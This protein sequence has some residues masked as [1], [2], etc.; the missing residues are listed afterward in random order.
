MKI[1]L[2][3]MDVLS[4]TIYDGY[5]LGANNR[6]SGSIPCTIC[7]NRKTN[8]DVR[9]HFHGSEFG[10]CMMKTYRN[11]VEGNDANDNNDLPPGGE[12]DNRAAS[13]LDGHS[14]ESEIFKNLIAA[15]LDAIGFSN[16]D[17]FE[18]QVQVFIKR[19]N[20][21]KHEF[22]MPHKRIL[23][24]KEDAVAE[25]FIKSFKMI[26]HLDG[27][28]EV[29]KHGELV[30]IECKS[31]GEYT[32]KKIKAS[33][34]ISD[35]WYG[36]IQAYMLWNHSIT[37]FYLIVKNRQSSK[38]LKPILI[39]RDDK[40]INRRLNILYRIFKAIIKE[41]PVKFKIEKEHKTA[42][43]SECRFCDYKDDCFKL[44]LKKKENTEETDE[45][46]E[47]PYQI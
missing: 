10:Q 21:G 16:M 31:V 7:R 12:L 18:K 14:H 41:D 3:P 33:S 45:T 46:D 23:E 5:M 35:V 2:D 8:G 43:D 15:G 39:E 4:R 20:D 32:W 6:K 13:L 9:G 27:L 30:G 26:L 24:E 40:Y 11:M 17:E 19:S 29:T 34:E 36:Q 38:I 47:I 42:K 28:L 44:S 1:E 25:G 22:T 37:R